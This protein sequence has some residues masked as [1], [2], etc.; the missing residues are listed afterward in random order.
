[1]N[2][3][4]YSILPLALAVSQAVMA[5]DDAEVKSIEQIVVYG[6][7]SRNSL[8]DT[9]SSIAVIDEEQ[10]K[11]GQVNS[12][13]D[14]LQGI[15]NVVVTGG[16]PAIRGQQGQGV[17]QGFGSFSSGA[18]PRISIMRD[19]VA[20]PYVAKVSGDLGLWDVEQ[21]EV[22]R[23]PQSSNSGRNSSGG[24]VY[25]KTK[26]PSLTDIEA[27]VRVGYSDLNEQSELAGVVSIPLLEDQLGVRASV[28]RVVGDLHHTFQY[29][30]GYPFDPNAYDSTR[31]D[32]KVKWQPA[33]IQGLDML[34]HYV[35]SEDTGERDWTVEGP[36]IA[37]IS[38][39]V[40]GY[41]RVRNPATGLFVALG[42][43]AR[44]K[45]SDYKRWSLRTRY[46][47]NSQFD[48]ELM[49]SDTDYSYIFEQYPTYWFVRMEEEGRT[50]DAKISYDGDAGI[51]GYLGYYHNERDQAFFRESWYQ[52]T[53]DSSSKAI[54]GE[55]TFALTDTT[56][57]VA[58]GRVTDESQFRI[59]DGFGLGPQG[60][61]FDIDVDNRI[62]LPK[63]AVLHDLGETTTLSASFRK[64]YTSG[65]GDFH[66]FTRTNYTFE[67]EYVDTFELGARATLLDG[68]LSVS[69]NLFYNDYSNY[70]LLGRGP[71]GDARDSKV[72]NLAQVE[73][74]G[75]E[76]E[77]RLAVTEDLTLSASL[78]LLDSNIDEA[79]A[80]NR[81]SEG[82]DLPMAADVTLGFGA[83][84]WLTEQLQLTARSNY[85]GEYY[86]KLGGKD[87]HLAGDYTEVNFS[88]AYVTEQWRIN[89]YVN[90]A[91]DNESLLRGERH[92]GMTEQY[93]HLA[94]EFRYARLSD[95]RTVGISF[96]YT[97]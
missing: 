44:D 55:L 67:P 24:V 38:D 47:I 65:G 28:Q 70:Q 15:A 59:F 14:A 73:S 22:L 78:G 21:I 72:L 94:G 32:I 23:G 8:K 93:K 83:E 57:L 82:L 87:I 43:G 11:S 60:L 66:W 74:Y 88:V 77:A 64:G 58:G 30:Q 36:E 26:E 56:R 1:M 68:E 9:T 45:T 13:L 37:P 80:Q 51:S 63:L 52:G 16:L 92:D 81:D 76:T 69:A 12:Y 62:Y 17:S 19:G 96:S 89:A 5:D 2:K 4:K 35:D 54:Y 39:W 33:G 75:L 85:V 84:Y 41:E 18:K 34:L 3:L 31:A 53:D 91:F 50:Y 86:S 90:N 48:F 49:V 79:N 29:D 25:I 40:V 71:S 46:E 27:G 7:N 10:L 42:S 6:E 97:L 20:E 61:R 95:P